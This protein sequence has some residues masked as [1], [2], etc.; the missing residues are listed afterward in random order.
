MSVGM[1][2]ALVGLFAG[3][4]DRQLRVGLFRLDERHLVIGAINRGRRSHQQMLHLQPAG[5]FHDIQ[6]THDIAV[7][8]GAW[9]FERI[10]HPG[11]RR[12]MNDHIGP[13]S[14]R[15]IPYR[16]RVF[17]H[18]FGRGEGIAF[19]EHLMATTFELYVVVIRHP[20]IAVNEEA[21]R[22]QRLG[23]MKADEASRSGDEDFFQLMS[24]FQCGWVWFQPCYR[25]SDSL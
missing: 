24:A 10:A 6:R 12:E 11:L 20:V 21:F 9:I 16:V 17:Q 4:V 14:V 15:G 8:I 19:G 7:D 18:G 25:D 2:H 1:A 22:D 23:K 5:R 3:R 13:E